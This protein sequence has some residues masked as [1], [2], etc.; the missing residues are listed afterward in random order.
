MA[1]ELKPA[2]A[3]G[4]LLIGVNFT[5][6]PRRAK[7]I[8]AAFGRLAGEV[9]EPRVELTGLE[10]FDG[11]AAFEALLARPGPWLGAFDF[12]FG[13]PREAV[14]DLGW[15]QHWPELVRHCAALGKAGFRAALDAYRESRPI[16]R[17]YAHRTTDL[18]ARSHS[19]LKLVN[20]PVGLMFLEGAPRLLAAGATLPGL[21]AG[22]PQRIAV[23]AYPGLLARS[24][25]RDSYKSDEKR[26]QTFERRDARARI[27][28]ALLAGNTPGGLALRLTPTQQTSLI[29]DA[30]GDRLDAALAL[31]QAAR[32]AQAGPP[33]YGLPAAVDPL[34]GW[35]AGV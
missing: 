4:I 17:R 6:A 11:W 9:T 26:K 1:A 5:S 34:E 25:T 32:C 10:A 35:I 23:E 12:P 19:P 24:I 16:G 3:S 2:R 21:H 7:P 29:D 18:P 13:L 8:T 28:T 31:M 20:P 33:H 22:D 27:I 15:Q 30:A 14:V